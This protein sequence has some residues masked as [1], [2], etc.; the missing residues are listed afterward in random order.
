MNK[1]LSGS[2][3]SEVKQAEKAEAKTKKIGSFF[4]AIGSGVKK[5]FGKFVHFAKENPELI[6]IGS[7]GLGM[8]A[9]LACI[10]AGPVIAASVG[11]G[12][13]AVGMGAGLGMIAGGSGKE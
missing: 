5:I 1:P 9:G 7:V 8:L 4:E 11:G 3:V 6:A 13:S 2:A 10:P 12:I